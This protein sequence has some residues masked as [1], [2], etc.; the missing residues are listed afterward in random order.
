MIKVEEERLRMK[1]ALEKA[2]NDKLTSVLQE[3]LIAK[4]KQLHYMEL[5]ELRKQADME[6]KLQAAEN[7]REGKI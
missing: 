4:Q 7:V 2:K 6:Q 3:T 5:A 1:E